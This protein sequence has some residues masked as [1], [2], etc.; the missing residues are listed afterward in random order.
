MSG[1]TST[2]PRGS[3]WGR[4]V[5]RSNPA[6]APTVYGFD[7]DRVIGGITQRIPEAVDGAA[8]AVVEVY[9]NALRPEVLAELVAAQ[10]FV[11]TV[12]EEP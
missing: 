10:D 1:L 3:G 7:E 6:V 4:E 9:E 11:G 2:G 8:D 12:K 5:S